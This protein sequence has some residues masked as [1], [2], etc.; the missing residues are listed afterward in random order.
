MDGWES[1]PGYCSCGMQ[2]A[3]TD[4]AYRRVSEE[5]QLMQVVRDPHGPAQDSDLAKGATH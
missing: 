3:D 4:K 1:E 5:I 2:C